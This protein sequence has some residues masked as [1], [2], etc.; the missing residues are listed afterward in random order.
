LCA[1]G[2]AAACLALVADLVA[3][4]GVRELFMVSFRPD[5]DRFCFLRDIGSLL[6]AA[7]GVVDAVVGVSTV[8]CEGESSVI[9]VDDN[10]FAVVIINQRTNQSNQ[11]NLIS[12]V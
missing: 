12:A 10:A 6:S 4:L 5:K 7:F 8:S 2:V 3:E 11:T 1:P 9:V